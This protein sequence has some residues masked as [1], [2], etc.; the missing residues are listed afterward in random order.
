M[1]LSEIRGVLDSRQIQLT[2][3]L[4]QNFLHD[5]NILEKIVAL[6]EV[7]P[8]DQV[9]E[10]GPGLGPLTDHL[11]EAGANVLAV[12]KDRRLVEWLSEKYAGNER[13]TLVEADALAWLREPGRSWSDWKMVSNLPYSI[14]SPLLI[15][16]ALHEFAPSLMVATLQSEVVRRITAKTDAEDYSLLSLFIQARFEPAG[17]FKVPAGCFFPPP[18]VDSACVALRRRGD[19]VVPHAL[20]PM[21]MRIVRKGFSE[22]RKMM[23]KLLKQE[24]DPARLEAGYEQA[25]IPLDQRAEK[26]SLGQFAILARFLAEKGV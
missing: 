10:V 7:K 20:V 2:K 18:D 19:N 16:L 3:S 4:G 11:L 26:V 24:W 6:G 12:E 25:R 23:F 9:L 13:L 17:W 14:G 15:D 5:A 8:G 1:K 21:F 22:R